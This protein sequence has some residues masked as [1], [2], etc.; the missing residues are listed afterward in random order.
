MPHATFTPEEKQ[1]AIDLLQQGLSPAT[2]HF[3]TGIPER[4]LRRWRNT[5][6]IESDTPVAEKSF[7]SATHDRTETDTSPLSTPANPNNGA[8]P[9]QSAADANTPPGDMDPDDYADFTFIREQ[10]MEYARSMAINLVADDPDANRRTLALTRVLDRIQWLDQ[11][12]PDRI[13]EQTIRFEFYYDGEVQQDPPWKGAAE[14]FDRS[15][16]D[17]GWPPIEPGST[18]SDL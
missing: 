2:V 10:L 16:S 17:R 13:P 9:A 8:V 1:S 5:L 14:G 4:T 18:A 11:I 15:L 6:H 12:L 3:S 7:P